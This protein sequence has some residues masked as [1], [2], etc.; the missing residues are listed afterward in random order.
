M[1]AGNGVAIDSSST[2][3]S[4]RIAGRKE[5]LPHVN[6]QSDPVG[7][8]DR[9]QY[10][11]SALIN[12]M[13][14]RWSTRS[15]RPTGTTIPQGLSEKERSHYET[16]I[17][18]VEANPGRKQPHVVVITDLAKDYDDLA[19]MVILKELHRLKVI[20]LMGFI[21]NLM[22]ANDRAQ[23]GR[24]ALDTLGLRDIPIATGTSGFPEKAHRKHEV[25][26]YEFDCNFMVNDDRV[27]GDGSGEKLLKKLCEEAHGPSDKLT[28]LLISSLE[29]IYTFSSKY[30]D[31]LKDA[32]CNIVLQGGYT[33]SPDGKLEPDE[34]AN[35]NRYDMEAAKKFHAFMEK[36]QIPS[37]VYTKV[38]AF[39]TPLTTDLFAEM[40]ATKHPIGVHL[41]KVQ[42]LQDL[43]FYKTASNEAQYR[44]APF[45]DK[46]W[47]LKNKTS[48]FDQDRKADERLPEG[49]EVIPWLT[50]VVVYDALAALGSSG[51]DALD[52][53]KVLTHNDAQPPPIHQIVGFTGPPSD[54]GIDSEQMAS[55]LS[56]FLKG[57]LLSCAPQ[58]NQ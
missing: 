30:P 52:A 7:I 49:D 38:A 16:L 13:R 50:K 34:A 24:G 10:S 35:N 4:G 57:S 22:P 48:W 33:I 42:V 11:L 8:Q 12:R 17:D 43:S 3:I 36:H 14:L 20:K 55:V 56:A 51:S 15:Q 54:P 32:V 25:L 23:F 31:L 47:Y 41:R 18:L 19:A 27:G 58:T 46:E 5:S 29:D 45:M 53:L 44:F 2:N 40:A 9:R 6:D 39:A 37:S 26:P 21:A 1:E 28:I